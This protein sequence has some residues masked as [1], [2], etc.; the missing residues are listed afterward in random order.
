MLFTL[1]RLKDQAELVTLKPG[2][3]T[4]FFSKTWAYATPESPAYVEKCLK[5]HPSAGVIVDGKIVSGVLVMTEGFI[6]ML[7]TLDEAR[8]KGY[9]KAT[10]HSVMKSLADQRFI[11]AC[12]VE[13]RNLSSAA[14]QRRIGFKEGPTVHMLYC[15]KPSFD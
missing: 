5:L 3:G 12:I 14:L 7:Y 6:G 11:P 1:F 13:S 2:A 8:G 10:M 15:K 4:D 9:A